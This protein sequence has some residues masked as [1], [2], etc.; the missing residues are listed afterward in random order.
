MILLSMAANVNEMRVKGAH[1]RTRTFVLF[2]KGLDDFVGPIFLLTGCT[3]G[4]GELVTQFLYDF[5][6]IRYF[7]F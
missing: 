6:Q 5:L 2:T 3:L 4:V 7:F 1:E